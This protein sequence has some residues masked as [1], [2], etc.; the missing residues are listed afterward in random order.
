MGYYISIND[1]KIKPLTDK[2][3][4]ANWSD[5]D[6]QIAIREAESYIESRLIRMGYEREQLRRSEL[7]KSICL[8]YV[9]YVILRDIYTMM[10]PSK[11]SGEEYIKWKEQVEDIMKKIENFEINLID[12]E[13]GEII[14]PTKK[15]IE[16]RTTTENIPR[17]IHMGA[18][19]EWGIDPSYYNDEIKNKK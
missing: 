14:I 10:S 6:I 4:K 18:N 16:I 3:I 9:R 17:A 5:D 7:I 15:T 1:V 19:Y 2:L 13:T 11:S 12:K 8:N